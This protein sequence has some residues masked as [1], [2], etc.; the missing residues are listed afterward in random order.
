MKKFS[1]ERLIFVLTFLFSIILIALVTLL[2][3]RVADLNQAVINN[4]P[5][6]PI[7]VVQEE[8]VVEEV[9]ATPSA[10]PEAIELIEA[11]P[12]A[13]PLEVVEE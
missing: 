11:T 12:A 8:P 3:M 7:G 5:V 13:K 1:W 10:T 4:Q 2:T 6:P 9:I